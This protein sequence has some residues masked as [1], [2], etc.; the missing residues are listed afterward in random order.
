[1]EVVD[2]AVEVLKAGGVVASPTDTV[3]GLLADA[4]NEEAVKRVYELKCRPSAKPLLVL[5][6]DM[7][8]A[9]ELAYIPDEIEHLVHRYWFSEDRPTT[10]V[11][12]AKN[13]NKLVVAGSE[14]IA[15]RRPNHSLILNILKRLQRPLVAPSANMHGNSPCTSYGMVKSVFG[16]NLELVIDGGDSKDTSPST[17]IDLSADQIRTIRQ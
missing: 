11:L 6:D 8:M 7:Q 4:T 14:T 15:I 13:A 12:K 5:V 10:V 17:I 16:D 2:R 3:Y 1:M 9:K